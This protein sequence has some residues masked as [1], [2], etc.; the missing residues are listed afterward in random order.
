MCVGVRRLGWWI[1]WSVIAGVI[2]AFVEVSV[3]TICLSWC[4]IFKSFFDSVDDDGAKRAICGGGQ[5][6]DG[7]VISDG[8]QDRFGL[9]VLQTHF[10]ACYLSDVGFPCVWGR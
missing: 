8:M 3:A 2:G 10:V 6:F 7:G 9:A 1:S 5:S 4:E